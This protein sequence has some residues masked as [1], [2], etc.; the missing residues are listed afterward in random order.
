MGPAKESWGWDKRWLST[1]DKWESHT[2][3]TRISTT[4]HGYTVLVERV[5]VYL[6]NNCEIRMGLAHISTYKYGY[7]NACVDI[8]K[9]AR[10][11]VLGC[12]K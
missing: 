11:I 1:N 3:V 7:A 2:K 12:V 9:F 10:N 6:I 5:T 8:G 4:D